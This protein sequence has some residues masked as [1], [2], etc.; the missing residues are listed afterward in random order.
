MTLEQ[1]HDEINRALN[2]LRQLFKPECQL[3]FIMRIPGNDEGDML[4]SNDDLG[5]LEKLVQRCKG[6]V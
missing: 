4:I 1:V 6:R 5:K 2:D 3:T